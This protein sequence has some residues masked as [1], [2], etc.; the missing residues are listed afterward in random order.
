MTPERKQYL[1]NISAEEKFAR[2][3]IKNAKITIK[4]CKRKLQEIK[5]KDK[6]FERVKK[7]EIYHKYHCNI[8]TKRI[9]EYKKQLPM[10]V[11]E[12][13]PAMLGDYLCGACP[14]CRCGVCSDTDNKCAICGQALKWE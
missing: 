10:K 5:N 14:R 8:A 13:M 7:Y 1:D 3:V 12:V 11:L 9:I 2:K 6:S 4:I